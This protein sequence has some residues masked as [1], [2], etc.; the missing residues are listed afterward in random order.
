MNADATLRSSRLLRYE[1]RVSAE[2]KGREAVM[3]PVERNERR[4]K[5]RKAFFRLIDKIRAGNKKVPPEEVERDVAAA[6]RAARSGT[7]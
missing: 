4:R 5:E 7:Q 2:G 1:A 6:V 3:A